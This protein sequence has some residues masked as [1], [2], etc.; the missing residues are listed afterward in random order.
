ME[1]TTCIDFINDAYASIRATTYEEK[2]HVVSQQDI[3]HFL[4]TINEFKNV[5]IQK[6]DIINTIVETVEKISW[7][8]DLDEDCLK[9]VNDI[10]SLVR[11]LHSVQIR[12]YVTLGFFMKR[13]IA[14][15][16][17]RI[18]KHSIDDLRDVARDLD[19]C[20]FVLATMPE[21]VDTNKQLSLV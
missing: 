4:D 7:F 2:I 9:K 11:E 8:S 20:F 14:V 17:I 13:K 12:K 21:F 1:N 16:E 19:A 6:A 18:L 10:I 3:D 15:K 5:I